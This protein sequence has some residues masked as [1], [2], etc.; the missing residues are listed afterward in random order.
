MPY[1]SYAKAPTTKLGELLANSITHGLGVGLSIA[2]LVIL[3]VRA[4]RHGTGWHLAG[5][6]V[7][8]ISLIVLY[9]AS[10]LYHAMATKPWKAVLQRL[11]HSAIFILIA[12]T[13]TP[14]L[15]IVMRGWMGWTLFG[16][17]WGLALV[18]LVLKLTLKQRFEKPPTWLY[19]LAGW[20]GVIVF[21]QGMAGIG[22]T[23]LLLL[24]LGGAAYSLGVIFYKW[25]S[26]PYSHAV[27][28]LFVLGGSTLHYFSV[29]LLA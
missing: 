24:M 28:H 16:L 21:W 3:I 5:F 12:G 27:W 20:L 18:M 1:K 4:A 10:T 17:M 8:G 2:G 19:L 26:L 15:L 22:P 13:Y 9:L 23:S 14:Y 6:L 29:L 25:R 7:F 11:D